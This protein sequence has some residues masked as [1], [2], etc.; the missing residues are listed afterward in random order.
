M[1]NATPNFPTGGSHTFAITAH[2][3]G[4]GLDNIIDVDYGT[5]S[6]PSGEL[7]GVGGN[8][9]TPFDPTT[10]GVVNY[11]DISSFFVELKDPTGA[12]MADGTGQGFI[13]NDDLKPQFFINNKIASEGAGTITLTVTKTGPTD[14]FA[15]VHYA[16]SNGTALSGSD[17]VARSGNVH[18]LPGQTSKS[19][20]IT[21]VNNGTSEP[22]ETFRVT[23][24][25]PVN[26][27]IGDA[28]GIGTIID[29]D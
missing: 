10:T 13:L 18:F 28:Q 29:N 1:W 2:R 9:G 5:V 8:S 21:L 14:L 27:T 19:I 26:A 25:A 15:D 3:I 24:T 16:T 23:L 4:T 6:S 7:V 11:R 12:T 22:T 17:S 20:T